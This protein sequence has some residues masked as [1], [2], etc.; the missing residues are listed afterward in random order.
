MKYHGLVLAANKSA[1]IVIEGEIGY[2][3]TCS[4]DIKTSGMRFLL[5]LEPND[6]R[7]FARHLNA[8]AEL[9]DRPVATT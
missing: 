1:S 8:A 5:Y 3:S 6:A 2:G 9:A 4:V 7:E